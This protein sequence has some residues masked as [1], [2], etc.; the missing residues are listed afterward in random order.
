MWVIFSLHIMH[1]ASE[2]CPESY[3]P[4]IL[5]VQ[6]G[7]MQKHA[8]CPFGVQTVSFIMPV[9][10]QFVLIGVQTWHNPN[11][12]INWNNKSSQMYLVLMTKRVFRSKKHDFIYQEPLPLGK[13]II[14]T[15]YPVVITMWKL[16]MLSTSAP[17]H[18]S[19]RLSWFT[20]KSTNRI[21]VPDK[22]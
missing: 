8:S 1:H 10:V 19:N 4:C 20:D 16:L 7:D 21:Q 11:D 9:D 6:E 17:V 5:A 12:Y 3:T 18:Y 14:G 13:I 15:N 2:V 22:L